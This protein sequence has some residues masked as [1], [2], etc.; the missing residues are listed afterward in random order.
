MFLLIC[1]IKFYKEKAR[2]ERAI[3][4]V[5]V[6]CGYL[7]YVYFLCCVNFTLNS[8]SPIEKEISPC[9]FTIFTLS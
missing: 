3:P 5:R 9:A 1:Q 2:I 7:N 6:K 8:L 4:I